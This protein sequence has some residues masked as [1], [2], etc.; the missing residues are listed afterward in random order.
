MTS[1][2]FI[3]K[4]FKMCPGQ[5]PFPPIVLLLI[6]WAFQ[7]WDA[8]PSILRDFL[9][10]FLCNFLPSTFAVCGDFKMDPLIFLSFISYFSFCTS[11][12]SFH[13]L[14]FILNICFQT[15]CFSVAQSPSLFWLFILYLFSLHGWNVFFYRSIDINYTAL[16]FC[17]VVSCTWVFCFHVR[18]FHKHLA[19]LGYLLR[20]YHKAQKAGWRFSVHQSG[21]FAEVSQTWYGRKPA[22]S[23]RGDPPMSKPMTVLVFPKKD[24]FLTDCQCSGSRMQ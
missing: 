15:F 9:E 16:K 17:S 4:L 6:H 22:D 11:F 12:W 23:L 5:S 21:L 2:F 10:S 1:W 19:I 24:H 14:S 3:K 7:F 8:Y 13:Q 20:F 18:T